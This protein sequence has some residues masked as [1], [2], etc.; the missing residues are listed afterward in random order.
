MNKEPLISVIVPIYNVE[1]YLERCVNSITS[2]T[3]KNLEIILV[4]DGS[5]DNCPAIC[6]NLAK[7]DNRIKVFHKSNGGLMAAW[8]DGVKISNGEFISFV[9]SDDWVENN[10]IEHLL[11]PIINDNEI[12][13]TICDYYVS[14]NDSQIQK[15]ASKNNIYGLLENSAFEN[16]KKNNL[17]SF[18]YY[19]WNKLF[20]RSL[21]E[22]NLSFC[23]TR[24]SLCEDVCITAAA[25]LDAKKIYIINKPLY[26][27]YQRSTSIVNSYN[28]NLIQ[29][30]NYLDEKFNELLTSKQYK[31]E[32]NISEHY[33]YLMFMLTKN[34][35]TSKEKN[36]NQ[37]LRE[38]YSSALF[39]SFKNC[40]TKN[41]NFS[42]KIFSFALKYKLKSLLSLMIKLKSK[43]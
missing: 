16:I 2:Q 42:F 33:V 7:L 37:L 32:K 20:K 8:I 29:Y 5:P 39:K 22:K 23:D 34:I 17:R 15:H 26:N 14:T 24:I 36:K 25:L 31:T 40:K 13:M 4:D 19:R 3:Y 41:L 27:Y 38:L 35:L 30:F 11:E 12:D 43:N 1:Q 21:I 6:D 18:P 28:K 9:D 10:Y